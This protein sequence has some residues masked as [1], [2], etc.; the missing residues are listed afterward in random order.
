MTDSPWRHR[1]APP[2]LRNLVRRRQRALTRIVMAAAAVIT[3]GAIGL[4]GWLHGRPPGNRS[5]D[6]AAPPSAAAPARPG[7]LL[8]IYTPGVPGSYA[9]VQAFTAATGVRPGVVVYY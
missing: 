1:Q 6:P 8:G 5:L 7:T 3:A 4:V 9:G 2:R